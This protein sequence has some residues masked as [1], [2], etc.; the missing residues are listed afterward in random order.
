MPF[1]GDTSC[2]RGRYA[3]GW[4]STTDSD[5]EVQLG[6]TAQE[7]KALHHME[8]MVGWHHRGV[9]SVRRDYA[10]CVYVNEPMFWE[11]GKYHFRF[12]RRLRL[13][14]HTGASP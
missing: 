14:L 1:Q 6:W 3:A 12:G 5:F 8:A 10:R 9:L 11:S 7:R 13:C 4:A 2:L